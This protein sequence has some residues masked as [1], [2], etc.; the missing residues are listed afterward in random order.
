MLCEY[1]DCLSENIGL[2]EA[3]HR[4]YIV[5][6][7]PQTMV[8][9]SVLTSNVWEKR[10]IIG[11]SSSRSRGRSS[12]RYVVICCYGFMEGSGN[13]CCHH[14]AIRM[15]D[16]NTGK[17]KLHHQKKKHKRQPGFVKKLFSSLFFILL[18]EGP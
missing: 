10:G 1:G 12:S 4:P 17:S 13:S 11:S 8:A 2:W 9:T 16:R 15:A 18:L 7:V 5:S 6:I 14:T 3:W